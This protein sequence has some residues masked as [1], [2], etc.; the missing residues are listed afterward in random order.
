MAA[1][2]GGTQSLHTNAMD[3]AM[4]LPTE[5]AAEL[6]LRT[7]QILAHETGIRDVA[8]PLGGAYHLEQET[9]RLEAEA[10]R[11][12]AEIDRRGGAAASIRYE[13]Q[14]IEKSALAYQREIESGRRVIVGVNKYPEDEGPSRFP[15]LKVDP[16][17]QS[18]RIQR[19]EELTAARDRARVGKALDGLRAAAGRDE[20]LV[21]PVLEC[22]KAPATLGEICAA[23][24]ERYGRYNPM[25]PHP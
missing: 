7:Q 23:L 16:R 9:D 5:R 20:N 1:V 6:A 14:E 11:Y 24:R 2:L 17:V 15:V 3:E 22:V 13:Q 12:I 21:P 18:D 25:E 10:E 4:A 19:L 8:D